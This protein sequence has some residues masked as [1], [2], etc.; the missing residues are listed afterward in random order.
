MILINKRASSRPLFLITPG[1]PDG[2]GPEI[3]W[4]ALKT[5]D[6]L[7]RDIE[8]LC[9]G[10]R[11]PFDEMGVKVVTLESTEDLEKTVGAPVLN[12]PF[13]WLLP[14]PTKAP[15]SFQGKKNPLL[16]GYQSG[17]SIQKATEL[18]LSGVA[19]AIVTGPISKERLQKGGF[20]YPGHTEMLADLCKTPKKRKN[21][22][23]SGGTPEVTM[24]LANDQ[25][26][27]S[28]VTTHLGLKDVSRALSRKKIRLATTQT[29][30]HLR[31]WWRIEKPR[32]AIT[33]LNPHAGE[34]GLFGKEEIKTIT[35]EIQALQ[36]HYGDAAEILG[37]FPADTLFAKNQMAE[38]GARFDAV[39][40]MYHDQGLIPVKL[41]DFRRTVNVTL[42]LPI[43]RTSVDHGVG[44]DIAKTGK[45]DPSSLQA[46]IELAIQISSARP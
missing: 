10:A 5:G 27:V 44:F 1:D 15:S 8:I 38:E 30:D 11:K 19:R 33:A 17:W 45:A 20:K 3:T 24:L 26:R 42:G 34:S 36:K 6:Y 46:A 12:E 40:C 25:L 28:L 18:V 32:V 23:V 7:R 29:I 39:V 22:V 2:I 14:A 31:A 41:L 13:V 4:K 43:V 21:G 35:P 37:P 16:E 9:V